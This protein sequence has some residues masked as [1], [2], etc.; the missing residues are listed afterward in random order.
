M[1]KVLTGGALQ[2]SS[3]YRDFSLELVN[4]DSVTLYY[5]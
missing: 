5:V 2:I 1:T 4:F 3:I